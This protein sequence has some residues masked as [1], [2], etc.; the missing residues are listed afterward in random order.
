MSFVTIITAA[1]IVAAEPE[2]KKAKSGKIFAT[3]KLTQPYVTADGRTFG[4]TVKLTAL[5]TN[6]G[7]LLDLKKGDVVLASGEGKADAYIKD[8]KA[9]ASLEI[10]VSSVHNLAG[11]NAASDVHEGSGSEQNDAPSAP[12]A[13]RRPAETTRKPDDFD[14]APPAEN[15]EDDL[16]F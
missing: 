6:A 2:E 1:G 8:G 16:P 10:I 15:T 12:P 3:A 13:P 9:Y 11:T 5:G 4:K 14:I 7:L